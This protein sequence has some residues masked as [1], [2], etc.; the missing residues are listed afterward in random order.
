MVIELEL[1]ERQEIPLDN[2]ASEEDL[3]EFE[4]KFEASDPEELLEDLIDE[5]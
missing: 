2:I 5:E 3:K 4:K 1:E